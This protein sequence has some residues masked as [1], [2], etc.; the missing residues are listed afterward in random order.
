MNSILFK[1]WEGGTSVVIDDMECF[2]CK[3]RVEGFYDVVR[4]LVTYH[5]YE[6]GCQFERELDEE[7]G[8]EM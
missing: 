7:D 2:E 6:C 8:V 3:E 1:K 4:N 5:C